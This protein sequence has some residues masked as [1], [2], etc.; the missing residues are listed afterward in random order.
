[1]KLKNTVCQ[2]IKPFSIVKENNENK[3]SFSRQ[4]FYWIFVGQH[5]F[6]IE[7]YDDNNLLLEP[8]MIKTGVVYMVD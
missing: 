6:T 1:M 3:L 5:Q 7:C 2:I 4:R 8:L